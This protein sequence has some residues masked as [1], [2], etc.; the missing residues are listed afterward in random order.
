MLERAQL[1]IEPGGPIVEH[2]MKA[3]AILDAEGDVYVRPTVA[4]AGSGRADERP[5]GD[6]PVALSH[7]YDEV[8]H[9]ITLFSG[10]HASLLVWRLAPGILLMPILSAIVQTRPVQGTNQALGQRGPPD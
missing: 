7:L 2:S 4:Q 8:A 5:R 6:P 9:M 1:A 10:K 3:G